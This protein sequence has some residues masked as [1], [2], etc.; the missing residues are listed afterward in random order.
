MPEEVTLLRALVTARHWQR[1]E[2][3]EAQFKRAAKQLATQ[4]SEPGISK[5]TVSPRQYE[6]W[7]YGKLKTA[8]WPD[9]SR[10]LEHMFGYPVRQLLGPASQATPRVSPGIRQ[11]DEPSASAVRPGE[12]EISP[13]APSRIWSPARDSG[14]ESAR[15]VND[16]SFLSDPERILAM[17]ARRALRF[18]ATADASNV[19]DESLDQ[20]QAELARLAFSYPQQPLSAILGDIIFVQEYVF[21]L[22]EGRQKPRQA[23]DLYYAGALAS[24]LVAKATH[25][26][27]DSRMAMTHARTA[28]LCAQNA[29]HGP[30]I[31]WVRGLQSLIAYW[32]SAP[33][34]A[35]NYAQLGA[36]IPGVQGTSGIWLASLEARA[37]SA[38]GNGSASREAIEKADD[39][40]RHVVNDDL[41]K[42]GGICS[43]SR[44]R[45][46]YYAA[47]ASA[48]LWRMN[49]AGSELSGRTEQYAAEAVAAYKGASHNEISFGD[50]SGAR[51]DLAIARISH[52]NLEGA[53]EAIQPVMQL[54]VSQRIH[55]IV[56]SV[57]NV[58]QA[59]TAAAPDSAIARDIQEEI[60]DY[61]RTPVTALPR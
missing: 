32:G 55:G 16:G 35:L 14:S 47:D 22:L 30:L 57:I 44:P 15:D 46:L 8:P 54:P 7:F 33:R 26:F 43:F 50:E 52:R 3:F 31:A 60:E 36:E 39:L 28:L 42:L 29:E 37:W 19:G 56:G 40:R 21:S 10:V 20:I 12:H 25:D 45:Q 24:G 11:Q 34:D 49:P 58:H 59:V 6:R 41:D 51:T 13:V 61:C 38:L 17:A 48:A 4:E 23:R 53:Y 18:G 9:A 5:V 27:G 1:F 2:T